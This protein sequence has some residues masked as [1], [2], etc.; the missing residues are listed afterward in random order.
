MLCIAGY[1][2]SSWQVILGL[3]VHAGT[4]TLLGCWEIFLRAETGKEEQRTLWNNIRLKIK[5]WDNK[6]LRKDTA[7]GPLGTTFKNNTVPQAQPLKWAGE[8]FTKVDRCEPSQ[9]S[10]LSLLSVHHCFRN[11]PQVWLECIFKASPSPPSSC[12]LHNMPVNF[13]YCLPAHL[14]PGSTFSKS[15]SAHVNSLICATHLAG[16]GHRYLYPCCQPHIDSF[17][18]NCQDEKKNCLCSWKNE[19]KNFM[20]VTNNQMSFY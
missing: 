17:P 14:S 5:L 4:A 7:Q 2:R 8:T 11:C 16:T 12:T 6:D 13:N 19:W 1:V 10:L 15:R 9:W 3:R 20:N 18:R